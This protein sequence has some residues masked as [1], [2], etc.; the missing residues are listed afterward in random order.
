MEVYENVLIGA[1]IYSIGHF[2]GQKGEKNIG[3]N[4]FQ[5][6]PIDVGDLLTNWKG[7][8]FFIEFK[9]NKENVKT[10]IAKKN[11]IDENIR[12]GNIQASYTFHFISFPEKIP[13]GEAVLFFKP[14]LSLDLPEPVI[15]LTDFI[16]LMRCGKIGI[17]SKAMIEY[18]NKLKELFKSGNASTSG[19][20]VNI[21]K[22]SAPKFVIV[23][24]WGLNLKREIN[25][26]R[27]LNLNNKMGYGM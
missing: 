10:E 14:Y 24:D 16:K 19:I 4:L 11:R 17:H 18:L 27:N 23:P 13:E 5:Q 7:N 6:T 20:I 21:E 15:N 8:C 9:R 3:I 25:I 2:A 1:F 12:L 22:D 26:N